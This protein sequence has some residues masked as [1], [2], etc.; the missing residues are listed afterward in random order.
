MHRR[1]CLAELG[2]CLV[3]RGRSKESPSLGLVR[4]DLLVIARR[5]HAGSLAIVDIGSQS[6]LHRLSSWLTESHGDKSVEYEMR[7]TGSACCRG[8]G[9][10]DGWFPI[11]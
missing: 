5:L 4:L 1:E 8:V 11:N 2:W 10:I 7:R 9:W 3:V 6:S